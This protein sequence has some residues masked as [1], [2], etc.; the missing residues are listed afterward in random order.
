M[1]TVRNTRKKSN[2]IIFLSTLIFLTIFLMI[3]FYLWSSNTNLTMIRNTL[4]SLALLCS[5]II[6]PFEL[7][8]VKKRILCYVFLYFM[9]TAY[10]LITNILYVLGSQEVTQSYLVCCSQCWLGFVA[11][12]FLFYTMNAPHSI[13]T[14]TLIWIS[15]FYF[16]IS[17]VSWDSMQAIYGEEDLT[18][19]GSYQEIGDVFAFISILVLS[20]LIGSTNQQNKLTKIRALICYLF[21]FLSII[22][23]FLNGSRSSLIS[24]LVVFMLAIVNVLSSS[25]Q[26][27]ITLSAI[28]IIFCIISLFSANID[29]DASL[30]LENRN[31]EM[32]SSG[33][34]SSLDLRNEFQASGMS[35][36]LENPLTGNYTNINRYTENDGNYIHNILGI[37]H[38]F[39]IIPFVTYILAAFECLKIF[40]RTV[41]L[42]SMSE[43]ISYGGIL[44]FSLVSILFFR[45]PLAFT[46]MFVVFGAFSTFEQYQN[47]SSIKKD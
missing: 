47:K 7:K 10:T 6:F 37:W 34:S 33:K 22:V 19:D 15:N 23:S 18:F 17:K 13:I 43:I 21:I 32:I 36:I 8:I 30:I 46:N 1:L 14:H 40:F 41:K 9:S 11:G 16:I 25:T 4:F 27:I 39:G 31:L 3:P 28:S 20:Q 29:I 26:K 38:Y 42:R 2:I 5:V 12:R 35:E 45:I 24:L 44:T